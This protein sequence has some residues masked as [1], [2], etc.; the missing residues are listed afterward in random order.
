MSYA[1]KIYSNTTGLR[2]NCTLRHR[3]R[4][5]PKR[6]FIAYGRK[7]HG[8][9]FSKEYQPA[10]GRRNGGP[11]PKDL[12]QAT[13]LTKAKL[14]GLLNKHIWLTR[15]QA[16]ELIEDP[17]TP[18]IE[19]LIANIVDKAMNHGDE[20]RFSFLL[21]RLI[22][23]VKDEIDINN[24]MSNLQKLTESQVID[25]GKDAIKFLGDKNERPT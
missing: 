24:Y 13:Q 5:F 8:K 7:N 10:P 6:R 2:V 9:K 14:E 15:R 18:L 4:V 20:K 11:L 16:E 1:P 22:G 19:L 23:K 12:R 17:D 25:L 3:S 21:D